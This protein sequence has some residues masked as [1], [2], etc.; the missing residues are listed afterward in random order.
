M[1]RRQHFIDAYH[2]ATRAESE[3]W[4]KVKG[5]GPG[6]A[7]YDRELWAKWLEAV[8]ATTAAARALREAFA[9][10]AEDESPSK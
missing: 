2:A 7:G 5:C 1:K 9:E 4:E 3:L 6:T 10:S 8:S